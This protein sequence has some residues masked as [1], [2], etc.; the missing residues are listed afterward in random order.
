MLKCNLM[1]R[2]EQEQEV[3][4]IE[5]PLNICIIDCYGKNENQ[6]RNNLFLPPTSFSD[7]FVIFS[8]G[9]RSC[10]STL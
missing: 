2:E 1:E 5:K 10:D 4:L 7:F 9:S 8:G 3:T 6:L